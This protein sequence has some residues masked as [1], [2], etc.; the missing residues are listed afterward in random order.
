MFKSGDNSHKY[1]MRAWEWS[2]V[3]IACAV[4]YLLAPD[5]VFNSEPATGGDTGSH[6]W[7]VKVLYDWGLKNA[8]LRPWN[9]GNLGGEGLLVHYF[10]LPFVLMALMGFVMPI[11]MAFNIGTLLPVILFPFSVWFC[12]KK[13]KLPFPATVLAPLFMLLELYNEGQTMWGGNLLSVLSG[14]FAHMYALNFFF[15][16]AGFTVDDIRRESG[17]PWRS[18]LCW[19]CV[20]LS[21]A[22]VF[23][24]FPIFMVV[25][26]LAFIGVVPLGR[27]IF[28]CV[29]MSILTAGL[30]AWY[31]IPMVLNN[32]YTTPHS[33]VWTFKSVLEEVFPLIL[34]PP[35]WVAA[36][37]SIF[38]VVLGKSLSR[39][40]K[41]FIFVCAVMALVYLGMF[42][43]F[44]KMNLVDVR[45][46]PQVQIFAL[47]LIAAFVGEVLRNLPPAFLHPLILAVFVL[48]PLWVEQ[49]ATK[50]PYWMRLNYES[51]AVQDK[52][53]AFSLLADGIRG[54]LDEPRVAFEHNVQANFVGTERVFEMLPYFA[55]RSTTESLYLQSTVL[56]PM[57]FQF[58]SEISL[59]PSCPFSIWP[60]RSYSVTDAEMRA[61]LLGI[62]SFILS[63]DALVQ[64]AKEASW[65]RTK[66][67][68]KPWSVFELQ[69]ATT[70]AFTL[71][72]EPV[73]IDGK[74]WRQ[75]FWDWYQSYNLESSFLLYPARSSIGVE[76]KSFASQRTDCVAEVR[77]DFDGPELITTCPN[78][79]HV[80]KYAYQPSFVASGGEDLYVVSPG[81]VGFFPKGERTKLYFG[82]SWSWK[83]S[84]WI[85]WLTLT[86]MSVL[87]IRSR[88]RMNGA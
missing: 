88:R 84:R 61:R 1:L 60:C 43:V 14:Q 29:I 71:S 27:S 13:W 53:P 52:Y 51:W 87:L 49:H 28:N 79:F 18:A 80:L 23:I 75:Q 70:M 37:A 83:I 22:Y 2:A 74:N 21:H 34:E 30:S 39:Q 73:L 72:K 67:E 44:R 19:V 41:R 4:L 8:T 76:S 36:F 78:T 17:L 55:N 26:A 11:G 58:T 82:E 31:L 24:T 86:L 25:A 9:A 20:A 48:T 62:G 6:F 59:S 3:L 42:F 7:P 45:A 69:P 38:I 56:A 66:V 15:F 46:V 68:S 16:A 81:F 47:L 12:C 50:A 32:R 33:F 77:T 5:Y 64:Q 85:S 35:V 63:S 54:T 40:G 65:L 57:L 10:P